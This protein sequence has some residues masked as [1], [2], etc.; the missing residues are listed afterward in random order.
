MFNRRRVNKPRDFDWQTWNQVHMNQINTY[1]KW[2]ENN[3]YGLGRGSV[4]HKWPIM[5]WAKPD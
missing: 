1:L 5:H 4:V 3:H 2:L